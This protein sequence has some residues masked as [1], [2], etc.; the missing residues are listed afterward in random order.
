LYRLD[1]RPPCRSVRPIAINLF[2]FRSSARE[3]HVSGTV[4]EDGET[5]TCRT[6]HLMPPEGPPSSSSPPP[7]PLPAPDAASGRVAVARKQRVTVAADVAAEAPP[8]SKYRPSVA[9]ATVTVWS[10]ALYAT[11]EAKVLLP[12]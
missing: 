4:E 1:R 12:P 6:V 2:R 11:D 3:E 8:P 9:P 5:T 7:P 10:S